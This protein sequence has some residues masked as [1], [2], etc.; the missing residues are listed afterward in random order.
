MT[1][2]DPLLAFGGACIFYETVDRMVNT[3][4][5]TI[6]APWD[7]ESAPGLVGEFVSP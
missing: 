6:H 2:A 5:W 1:M 4:V 7:T 3:P